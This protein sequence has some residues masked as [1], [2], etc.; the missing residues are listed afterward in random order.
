M[1]NCMSKSVLTSGLV[2]L[3]LAATLGVW[4]LRFSC[5]A[6]VRRE[7]KPTPGTPWKS[8]WIC[9]PE[10]FGCLVNHSHESEGVIPDG[11]KVTVREG[12]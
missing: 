11:A 6:V 4:A 2:V 9:T 5:H 12:K 10:A 1:E 3:L 8:V 7:C